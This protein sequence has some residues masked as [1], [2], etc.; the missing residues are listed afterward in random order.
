MAMTADQIQARIDTL[1]AARDSGVLMVR[2]G[3]DYVTYKSTVEMDQT[4]KRLKAQLAAVLGTAKPRVNYTVQK[5]KGYGF[6]RPF[7]FDDV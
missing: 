6:R 2:H 5:T 4:L 7:G 3:L 1:Q